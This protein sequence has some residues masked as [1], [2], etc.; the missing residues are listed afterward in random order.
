MKIKLLMAG[1]LGL[2]SATTF[3]QKGELNTAQSEYE[4]YASLQGQKVAALATT[5]HTSLINSKTAID[6][7]AANDKTAALPLTFALKGAIYSALAEQDT[8]PSTSAPLFA[9]AD[10]ALKKAKELDTKGDNKK[11]IDGANLNLA[12][13]KLTEGIKNYQTAK[14]E[15][16]YKAF[17]YYRTSLPDDTNAIYY[18][19]LSASNAGT[20]DPK[21]YPLAITNYNKLVTTNFSGND[22]VYLNLSTLDLMIKD[23]A[24]AL[25][26]AT[27]GVAKYPKNSELRK[28]EIEIS[29]QTGKQAEVLGK[30]ESAITNDPKNKTLYYYAG[31]TY[32]QLGDAADADAV[33]AKD[34]ATKNTKH[35]AAIDNYNKAGD[36]YKKAIEIDPDYFEA[37]LNYGYVL[38]R[39]AIDDFNAANKLPATKQKEYEA[40]IAKANAQ[41]DVSKPFLQKAVDLNPKSVD[42]L[43]NLR[44]YYRGKTDKA[45]AAEN[46]AKAAELKKQIDA[47]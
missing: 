16:A 31:L 30:I 14:Y 47:L 27:D 17:D 25:K 20:K 42:A 15:E 35:T 12:Q 8:V 4:K 11:L 1:L 33:K 5:A 40:M 43:N 13:Y 44:N 9:T 21:Y 10:E 37:N 29:L 23:T 38:E 26:A 45:H 46:T 22:K 41:F 36:M 2:V 7:A 19:A 32:S 18:T 39:P 34:D 28:R 6:K 3:A 24:N